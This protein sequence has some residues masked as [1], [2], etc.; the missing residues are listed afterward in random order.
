VKVIP[1]GFFGLDALEKLWQMK[2]KKT[3]KIYIK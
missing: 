1:G 3:Q 2:T